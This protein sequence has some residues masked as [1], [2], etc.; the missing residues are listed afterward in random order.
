MDCFPDDFC[1]AVHD[2]FMQSQYAEKV[3]QA[4]LLREKRADIVSNY[5]R[6]KKDTQ[7]LMTHKHVYML[8]FFDKLD[9]ESR[10]T[11]SRELFERWGCRV[12]YH[13]TLDDADIGRFISLSEERNFTTSY[14]LRIKLV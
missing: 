7:L 3:K 2:V 8:I 14:R 6:M 1:C 10:K 11:L 5:Q 4:E 13:H 12:E 9:E